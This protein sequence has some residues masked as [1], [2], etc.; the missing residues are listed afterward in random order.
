MQSSDLLMEL[1]IILLVIAALI[2]IYYY[3][4]VYRKPKADKGSYLAALEYLADGNEK[5]AIQKFK[6]TVRDDSENVQAYLRLGDLL[7]KRGFANNALKIHKDLT[8]RGNLFPEIRDKIQ[9]S[10]L[11]DYEATGNYK[12]AI[13]LANSIIENDKTYQ[14]E[15]ALR[16]LNYLE[17]EERWQEA[18]LTIK[19][20]FKELTP[21]LIKKS[22]LYLVFEG[23]KIQEKGEGR[24]ARIKFKESMKIDPECAAAFYC[25]GK[26]YYVEDRLEDA[27]HEWENLCRTLPKKAY[28]TFKDLERSWFEMGKFTEAEKL[29]K[30]ILAKDSKNIFATVALAEIY[31]KKED[32]ERALD[33]LDRL[34]DENQHDPQIVGFK[35][36]ILSNKNQYKQ[37]IHHAL[38]YFNKRY[39]LSERRFECQECQYKSDEPIWICPQCKSI[40]SFDF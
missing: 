5:W 17:R 12:V 20:C 8:F 24:E 26:S 38:D 22:A 23:L 37:A 35:L 1:L 32:F 33:V 39:D 19:K 7:R 30:G 25:L 18:F 40:D 15:A 28:L 3:T 21:L 2:I 27:I 29:Y 9:F 6:E 4:R 31:T 11:L 34:G 13:E 14:N 16:L 36:K 10:L